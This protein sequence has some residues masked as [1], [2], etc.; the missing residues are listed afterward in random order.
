MV[1]KGTDICQLISRHLQQWKDGIFDELVTDSERCARQLPC[2]KFRNE[3][4][5]CV[6]VFTCLML[7]GKVQSAVRFIANKVNSGGVLSLDASTGVPGKSVMDIL[8][9]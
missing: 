7:R 8:A 4:D 3:K 5:H 6:K 1:H 2:S 9:M